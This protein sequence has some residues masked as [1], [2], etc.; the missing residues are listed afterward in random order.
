MSTPQ[1]STRSFYRRVRR[2]SGYLCVKTAL[3]SRR[4]T[5]VA[6]APTSRAIIAYRTGKRGGTT[7]E[8][9][10]DLRE[11]VLGSPEISTGRF[12][13]Y[14]PAICDAFNNS[15]HGHRQDVQRDASE[16]GPGALSLLACRSDRA[17]GRPCVAY[18]PKSAVIRRAEQSSDP[19]GNAKVY[20]AH[21]RLQQE[22]GQS[23]CGGEPLCR[24]LQSVC[25]GFTKRFPRTPATGDTR[26][27][28]WPH[29]SPV[30]AWRVD[31]RR[32][33]GCSARSAETAP[34]RRRKFPVIQGRSVLSENS[35][36]PEWDG[37]RTATHAGNV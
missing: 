29:G 15:A 13:P 20:P 21:E 4:G 36:C 14:Q 33:G 24:P 8:F 23:Q 18:L 22:A 10:Q 19:H 17:R 16:L 28:A 1:I 5:F 11:R 7:G 6:L 9:V 25:A 34:E 32:A 12:T 2:L 26:D 3:P 27:G 35:K 37:V 31:R 30:V